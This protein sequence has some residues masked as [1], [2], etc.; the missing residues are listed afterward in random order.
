L[1]QGY[2]VTK[3]YAETLVVEKKATGSEQTNDDKPIESQADRLIK[4]CLDEKPELF[5]DQHGTQYVRVKLA[6][7]PLT[8]LETEAKSPDSLRCC[9]VYDKS[10]TKG[11]TK[12]NEA[13]EKI[14]ESPKIAETTQVSQYRKRI[15]ELKEQ[16]KEA[17]TAD[18]TDAICNAIQTEKQNLPKRNVI[19]PIESQQFRK[20]LAYLMYEA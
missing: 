2:E 6:Y 14:E 17:K 1:A 8:F 12:N 19:M 4:Y 9:D 15:T 10:N 18:E 7:N 16:L 13:E 5:F 3:R 20:W 11:E